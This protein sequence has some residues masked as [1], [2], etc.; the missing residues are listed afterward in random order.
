MWYISSSHTACYDWACIHLQSYIQSNIVSVSHSFD[1]IF[2][3][4]SYTHL[5]AVFEE[6][7]KISGK[8]VEETIKS[9]LSGD[10]EK[11]Y[12]AISEEETIQARCTWLT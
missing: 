12:L 1:T 5:C 11:A 3:T 8:N 10:V 7:E 2:A 9:R 4:R 6:Y